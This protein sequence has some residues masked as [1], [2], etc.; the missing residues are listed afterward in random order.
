M[1]STSL[2]YAFIFAFTLGVVVGSA[3]FIIFQSYVFILAII[4]FVALVVKILPVMASKL[5]LNQSKKG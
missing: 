3:F 1:K 5:K 4:G 2:F